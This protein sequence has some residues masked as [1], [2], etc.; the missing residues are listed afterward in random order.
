M[1]NP[2]NVEIVQ[3][4]GQAA[5]TLLKLEVDPNGFIIGTFD[6]GES[7]KLYQVPIAIFANVNGLV[8]GANGTF[9]ISRESGELLLKQAGVG[10]IL[11]ASNVD[12][13]EEL[14]KVQEL[15]NTIRANARV[16]A[17]E[18]KNISTVLNELNQ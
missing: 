9:E 14:L 7:R 17:T 6:S 16:A 8:A 15:G 2:N 13:T 12:T 11:E 1:K 4:D 10:G 5:G 3:S 18:F